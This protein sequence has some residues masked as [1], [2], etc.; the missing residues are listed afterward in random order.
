MRGLAG[1][2]EG[3]SSKLHGEKCPEKTNQFFA[4]RECSVLMRV[5]L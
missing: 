5:Y 4:D 3:N 1:I 2:L